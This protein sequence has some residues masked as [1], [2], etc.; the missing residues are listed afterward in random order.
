MFWSETRAPCCCRFWDAL[1]A[2]DDEDEKEIDVVEP[3]VRT[4]LVKGKVRD[5]A[6][7]E[8]DKRKAG[9]DVCRFEDV[10]RTKPV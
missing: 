10:S 2:E 7:A 1:W 6:R 4:W 3:L 5:L 9:G 8:K